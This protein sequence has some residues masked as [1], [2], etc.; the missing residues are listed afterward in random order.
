MTTTPRTVGWIGT[1]RMGLELA[2]RVARAGFDVSATNRTRAKAEPLTEH[3]VTVVDSPAGL[4]GC[5]VVI[6][7]LADGP[8]VRE[9]L[10]GPAGLFSG[11]SGPKVV[12]DSSSIAAEQ[13][14]ALREELAGLGCELVAAPVSGNPKT[15]MSGRLAVVASGPKES[16]D[17]VEPV[18]ATFGRSVTYVGDG[19]LARTVKIAH[20]LLLGIVTQ[21]LAETAVLAERSGVP[22]SA[23]LEFVNDSVMGSVFSRYKTPAL[24]N[25]DFHPTFTSLLL[26]K[27]LDLGLSAAESLG[28]S[29]PLTTETR[30]QVQRLVDAGRTEN[31]FAELVVQAA[32]DAGYTIEPEGV[33]VDDGLSPIDDLG[34]VPR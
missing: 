34:A 16:F 15:V 31:D 4:A 17:T 21:A 20:N 10:L 7:M 14:T 9:A 26:R 18:L 3:G 5:D 19:D 8:A 25:L 2:T 29:L 24:V 30:A 27:D 12:V 13:S 1:G 28:V 22:R 32:E 23:Y 6:T 33:A 11:G